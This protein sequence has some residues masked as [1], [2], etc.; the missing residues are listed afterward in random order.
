MRLQRLQLF[1]YRNFHRIDI[2][3][4]RDIGIFI[5]D[6]AQG[7]SNLLE[8]IYLLATMR[9]LRAE[10][11]V[12]LIRRDSLDD[13]LPAARAVAE[14][15]TDAG[16]L[17]IE[18][19]VVSRAG[20]QGPVAT[21]TVRV[22][23]VPKRLSDA[24]GRLTA[25]LFS[26]DDLEM[27]GG[28]PSLRRRNLDITLMQVDQSYSAA[29]SRYER[30]LLQRNHLLKRV[31][32]GE[33]R[34]DELD[35]W[36]DELCKDGGVILQRR[37]TALAE[38][39]ALAGDYHALLAP[40]ESLEVRYQPR[41]DHLTLDFASATPEDAEGALAAALRRGVNR[42]IAAGMTLQGPHRDD[43]L[44]VLNGLPASGY[45]SRAQQRTIALSLRLAEARLLSLR[46]G[47]AP[48]LLL[49]DVLS[50]M[51]A[52]RRQSVLAAIGH[53]DQ[54]LVTGTDWDRFPSDFVSQAALF[55]VEGGDVRPL[56]AHSVDA[57]KDRSAGGKTADS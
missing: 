10:T 17:K 24:V 31:R 15:E 49:D 14:V 42:D 44:F 51:D 12:Q 55:A 50:E 1:D 33:A 16:P 52:A 8:A 3:F 30:V 26:A 57:A 36:D 46:R 13:V 20:A 39:G 27:I 29:R 38:L 48:I 32:D 18:V 9:G 22:N 53:V 34:P 41:I 43:V 11:D 56:I 37:A 28:A 40:G 2:E 19:A 4:S 35:F 5:G 21:K 45:A 23:G 6:N 25:V 47:E 7:K 54:M